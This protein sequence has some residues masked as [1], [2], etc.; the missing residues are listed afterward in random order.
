MLSVIA[1]S[2]CTFWMLHIRVIDRATPFSGRWHGCWIRRLRIDSC[3]SAFGLF[4]IDKG[5]PVVRRGR[6]ATG[7]GRRR[8][9]QRGYRPLS[10]TRLSTSCAQ[11]ESRRDRTACT[12]RELCGSRE[13]TKGVRDEEGR[14]MDSMRID[15][16]GCS[17]GRRVLAWRG[18]GGYQSR[19][20]DFGLPCKVHPGR[21]ALLVRSE[22]HGRGRRCIDLRRRRDAG[23]APARCVDG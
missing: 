21:R 7:R 16:T 11:F 17:S 2:F 8:P 14:S 10:S 13:A 19:T 3:I 22:R 9:R 12:P 23:M 4:D 1:N 20:D 18:G 6:K 5:K 15:R